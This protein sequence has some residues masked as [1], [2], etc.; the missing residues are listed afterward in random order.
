M[1]KNAVGKKSSIKKSLVAGVIITVLLVCDIMGIHGFL[2]YRGEMMKRYRSEL[3]NLLNYVL[4]E[5]DGDDLKKCLESGTT[6]EK[7]D[8]LQQFMKRISDSFNIEC[9]YIVKPLNTEETDNA[10][11][12]IGELPVLKPDGGVEMS[13]LVPGELTG[14][15]FSRAYAS[16]LME[17]LHSDGIVYFTGDSVSGSEY[18]GIIQ[19]CDSEGNPF[20]VLGTRISLTYINKTFFDYSLFVGIWVWIVVTVVSYLMLR[21][22]KK[23]VIRP[24]SSLKESAGTF[25]EQSHKTEDPSELVLKEPYISAND[26]IKELSDSVRD[27]VTGLK[28]YMTDLISVTKEKERIGAELNVAASIQEGMLPKLSTVSERDDISLYAGMDPA[29]E[30]GGDFYDFFF[31]DDSRLVLVIADVSGKGV[32]AALFMARAKTLIR[33]WMQMGYEPGEALY[34]V[35]NRLCDGNER[36]MFV[37]AWMAVIDLKTGQGIAVNAGHSA[38]CICRKGGNFEVVEYQHDMMLAVI[39]GKRFRQHGFFLY[40]GDYLFVYT[41]GVSESMNE[42]EELFGEKR[43][44]KALNED[45]QAS[46]EELLKTVR[47]R[48]DDFAGSAEQFDDITMMCLKITSD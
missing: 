15:A 32:P 34:Y 10:V 2:T 18:N 33:S 26:E 31:L 27:M 3:E 20:A 39:K 6:S 35:N 24:L 7:Y 44:L 41:D 46:P 36:G 38:P 1:Q 43:L 12:V 22:I 30:V 42:E 47:K 29:K 5:A 4:K 23:R 21:W 48:V 40:P 13:E 45:P 11:S 14:N 17:A 19:V 9:L 37:T 8:S 28:R 25:V 16:K